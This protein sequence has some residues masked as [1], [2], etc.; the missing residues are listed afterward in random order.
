MV[1]SIETGGLFDGPFTKIMKRLY[2]DMSK[3]E[4]SDTL[5][6][7]LTMINY[8]GEIYHAFGKECMVDDEEKEYSFPKYDLNPHDPRVLCAFSGGK[9]SLANVLMLQDLGYEPILFFITG[10][11][12]RYT[13]EHESSRQLAEVLG[14]ELVEQSFKLHGKNDYPEN[15]VKNQ[16]ILAMML[17]YGLKR[18]I[19][20]YSFGT[21]LD[22]PTDELSSE[23]MLSDSSDL[24]DAFMEFVNSIYPEVDLPFFLHDSCEA[25][26]VIIQHDPKLLNYTQSCMAPMRFKQNLIKHAESKYGIELLPNRCPSCYK[27]CTE[28]IILNDFGIVCYPDSYLEHCKDVI[29]KFY[30]KYKS[31]EYMESTYSPDF[32]WTI[33]EYLDQYTKSIKGGEK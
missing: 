17:D 25:Y 10:V 2:M 29:R 4:L 9:D 32:E 31:K 6:Y 3:R 21:Y 22:S 15:P 33:K 14:L 28:A 8:I 24:F 16:F 18:G 20:N 11:N 26:L 1:T 5:Y 27:C 12:Y 23:Y 30:V 19:T 13:Y 7:P